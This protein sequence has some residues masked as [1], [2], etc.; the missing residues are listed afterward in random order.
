[1]NMLGVGLH[2]YG[3]MQKAFP[4]LVGFMLSQ[5]ALMAIAS[6]PLKYWRSFRTSP[7]SSLPTDE[8]EGFEFTP[9]KLAVETTS[10]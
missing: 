4:W 2:S 10:E 9:P 7:A 3:F 5:L 8:R 1:V 6:M